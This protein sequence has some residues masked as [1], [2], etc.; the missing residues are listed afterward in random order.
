MSIPFVGSLAALI[1][2][3][4]PLL[5]EAARTK[6]I[7]R[8]AQDALP[9]LQKAMAQRMKD[10]NAEDIPQVKMNP[11]TPDQALDAYKQKLIAK[12]YDPS[13]VK[14]LNIP[15]ALAPLADPR[16]IGQHASMFGLD[17]KGKINRDDYRGSQ[18]SYNPNADAA[19]LAHEMGHGVSSK[20]EVGKIINHLRHNPRL[21][22]AIAASTGIIPIIA[23]AATPGDDEY[24]EAIAGTVA[25]AA[26]KLIDE[27]LAT[28]NALAMM[29]TAGMRATLGQRGKLATGLLSYLAAPMVM[30]TAGT[31]FG[32]LFDEN[33]PAQ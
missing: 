11:I 12:G 7:A 8:N 15:S 27:G 25:L 6:P 9:A 32:N 13:F 10:V 17:S 24:D 5:R 33:V 23:A 22:M 19:V 31:A 21:T 28:K 18:V 4:L 30:G 14:G 3:N 2:T 29:D 20:T 26:P 1:G 16:M